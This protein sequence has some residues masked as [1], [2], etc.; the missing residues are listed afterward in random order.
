MSKVKWKQLIITLAIAFSIAVSV[1][2]VVLWLSGQ[3]SAI[4]AT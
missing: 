3:K 4:R 2:W 1:N